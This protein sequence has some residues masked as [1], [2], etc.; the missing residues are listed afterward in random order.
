MGAPLGAPMI[1][2]EPDKAE[3]EYGDIKISQRT[4]ET[5]P[6][7]ERNF[8][9]PRRRVLQDYLDTMERL[10][11][12]GYVYPAAQMPPVD[13]TMPQDGKVT[14]GPHSATSWVNSLGFPPW[15]WSAASTRAGCPSAWSSQ[16]ALSGTATCWASPMPGSRGRITAILR[17]WWRGGFCRAHADQIRKRSLSSAAMRRLTCSGASQPRRCTKYC[18][19][20]L[21]SMR[22]RCFTPTSA[23]R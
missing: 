8:W 20:A 21:R 10:H 15:S 6:D 16:R 1:G 13:E 22:S 18:P 17:C 2:T 4:L 9:G 12:D 11:L 19:S 3:F 7:A 5:D 23:L 14:D